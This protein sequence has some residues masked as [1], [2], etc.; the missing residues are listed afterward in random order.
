[1]VA[2][3]T[4]TTTED[5]PFVTARAYRN[6]SKATGQL[7]GDPITPRTADLAAEQSSPLAAGR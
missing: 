3:T 4:A 5:S 7:P 1:M 6:A 2:T